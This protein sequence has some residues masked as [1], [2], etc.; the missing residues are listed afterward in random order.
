MS[1]PPWAPA[2]L[3]R[4]K[5]Y[6]S[7]ILEPVPEQI[8]SGFPCL[9]LCNWPIDLHTLLAS[10]SRRYVQ[11]L[12]K[13]SVDWAHLC[14]TFSGDYGWVVT[15]SKW[16]HQNA[17][18]LPGSPFPKMCTLT[19]WGYTSSSRGA[20]KARACPLHLPLV[21]AQGLS[22]SS[23]RFCPH[24]IPCTAVVIQVTSFCPSVLRN[25]LVN[26]TF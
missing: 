24:L 23:H 21:W 20:R 16:C 19:F 11:S 3:S 9:F 10:E 1:L 26:L 4:P 17:P 2:P 15:L 22:C 25:M 7:A 6:F 8:L 13:G 14:S 5:S 18:P 12:T